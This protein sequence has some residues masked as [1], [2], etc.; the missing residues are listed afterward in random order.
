MPVSRLAAWADCGV[1]KTVQLPC[2]FTVKGGG[3]GPPP[4]GE[5]PARKMLHLYLESL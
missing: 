5:P 2:P 4:L 1:W 3:S